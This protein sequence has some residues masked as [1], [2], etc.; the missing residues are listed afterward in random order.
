MNGGNMK[1]YA[2]AAA[3]IACAAAMAVG[4]QK[5]SK[6]SKQEAS[7]TSES[8]SSSSSTSTSGGVSV[9]TENG[10][11]TVTYKG[12]EVFSG[13]T[14]GVVS[15]RSSSVNGTEYAAAFDGDKVLWESASGAAEQLK[16]APKIEMPGLTLPGVEQQQP[17]QGKAAKKKRKDV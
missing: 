12:D 5:Q 8:R 3:M 13:Q 1:Q 10:Q 16:A 17:K 14:S 4:G 6:T 7:A 2:W 11:T 9:R 15:A